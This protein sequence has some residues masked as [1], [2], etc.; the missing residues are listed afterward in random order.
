VQDVVQLLERLQGR[1]DLVVAVRQ[2]I[3][4]V[5]HRLRS[6]R[7]LASSSEATRSSGRGL[8]IG[9]S[10]VGCA[11]TIGVVFILLIAATF[12]TSNKSQ[13]GSGRYGQACV[14]SGTV[15]CYVSPASVGS[16]CSCWNGFAMYYGSVQ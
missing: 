11:A 3:D 5:L 7:P 8:N 1:R 10:L 2:D 16:A 15:G 9:K 14:I 4:D 6:T 12:C 13:S